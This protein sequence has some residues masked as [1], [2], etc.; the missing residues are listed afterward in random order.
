MRVSLVILVVIFVVAA[1]TER[2]DINT[3]D[4]PSRVVIYGY[5]TTDTI[6]VRITRSAG[7][8]TTDPPVG[9]DNAVVTITDNDG[10]V[11]PLSFSHNDTISGLYLTEEPNIYGK[12]E[13]T[14]KLDININ[15]N[16]HYYAEAYLQNINHIDSIGLR[17]STIPFFRDRVEVLLYAENSGVR[18]NYCFFVSINDSVVNSNINRW[19]V[20]G[21]DFFK[22]DEYIDGEP[23]YF[24]DQDPDNHHN[25][26]EVLKIGDKVS[27]NINALSDD[28]AT[29]ISNV[30]TE[31]RGS[32]PIF[33]GPPAN[34]PTNIKSKEGNLVLGFFTAY[35]SRYAH[36]FV[37]QEFI[38]R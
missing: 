13:K 25:R 17:L 15:N 9:V 28:Y 10:N 32:N 6:V 29:F 31:I 11:I 12:E 2:I 1:C 22:D 3:D 21:S 7:Y 36:T 33:G 35:P 23:C 34:V 24:L 19:M 27:L 4:A 14:Y 30:Q 5:V 37:K 8:F 16:E 20:V 38:V 26:Y 18:T